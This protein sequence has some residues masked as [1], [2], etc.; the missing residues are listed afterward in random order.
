MIDATAERLKSF[1]S[2]HIARRAGA[3]VLATLGLRPAAAQ[4]S[5]SDRADAAQDHFN[6]FPPI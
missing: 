5:F 6:D 1:C 2:F 3:G 4:P